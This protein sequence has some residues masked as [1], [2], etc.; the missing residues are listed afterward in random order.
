[1]EPS[2]SQKG[3]LELDSELTR[4]NRDVKGTGSLDQRRVVFKKIILKIV[5]V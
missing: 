2:T 1:M 4:E 5:T 3:L